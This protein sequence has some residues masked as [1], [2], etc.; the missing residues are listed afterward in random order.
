MYMRPCD[1]DAAACVLL[2]MQPLKATGY[3][4]VVMNMRLSD[5]DAAMPNRLFQ[6]PHL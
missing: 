4:D 3:S 2:L 5:V 6:G 1:V